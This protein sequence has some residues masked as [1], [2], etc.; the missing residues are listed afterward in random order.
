MS[1]T[2]KECGGKTGRGV[3]RLLRSVFLFLPGNIS[4]SFVIVICRYK[5]TMVGIFDSA[6]LI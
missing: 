1:W 2:L 5:L 6:N 3:E 4:E